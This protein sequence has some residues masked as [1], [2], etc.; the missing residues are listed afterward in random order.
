MFSGEIGNE[1]SR[2]RYQAG[3]TT[4]YYTSM[5][6]FLPSRKAALQLGDFAVR[7]YGLLWL[8]AFVAAWLLL[9]RLGRYRNLALSKADWWY[10]LVWGM[11][12]AVVGGRLGYV[13]L[14]EPG[15]FAAHPAEILALWHGGMASH[16]GII[17]VGLALAWVARQLRVSWLDILDCIVVPAA[18]GL[19]IGRIGNWINQELFQLPVWAWAAVGKDLVV[20]GAAYLALRWHKE[21]GSALAAF[22]VVYG[23]LRF[24]IEFVRL[25]EFNGVFGLTRGQL[26][27]I[28]IVLAGVGIWVASRRPTAT[29]RQA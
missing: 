12:G 29:P 26:Y 10:V 20:A 13:V 9:P 3:C 4:G 19:A 24:L 6:Q 11:V 5:I 7:W 1:R 25:Q 17:G 27:T 21:A 14:Y 15:Y 2:A 16:G 22:L 18:L 23:C 28:P 8:I